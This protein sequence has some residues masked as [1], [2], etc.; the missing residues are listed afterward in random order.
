MNHSSTKSKPEA[1]A[2]LAAR[3]GIAS[4]YQDIWGKRHVT[5]D[6]TRRVLLAAMHFSSEFSPEESLRE[7]EEREWRRLLPP[8]KVLR[9]G[10]VHA[11]PLSLPVAS[12]KFQHRW[13]ITPEEG[14]AMIGEFLPSELPKLEEQCLG[15]VDF[16]RV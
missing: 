12:T 15:G 6:R 16:L 9:A 4:E 13:I 11:I 1:L 2:K 3:C 14:T 5:S 7:M 10:E 8:V